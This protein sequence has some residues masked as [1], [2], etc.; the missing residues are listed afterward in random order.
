MSYSLSLYLVDP[1]KVRGVVGSG[2]DKLRRMMGGAFKT[3]FP[4]D[5]DY[6]SHE[7][8]RGAPTRYDA[9]RAV[10]A[11][12]PFVEEF[13]WQYGY[14]Y[15][16]VCRFHGRS[17]FNNCFSPFR[18][19]WLEEVDKGLVALGIRAVE[20]SGFSYSSLPGEL[21]RPDFVPGYG[22]WSAQECSSALKQ[23]EASTPEQRAALDSEVLEAIESVVGWLV[24]AREKEGAGV[25]GFFY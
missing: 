14:A 3:Q 24:K 23:W 7:I 13:A 11:G 8:E 1:A 18:S 2:D 12:G 9:L 10:I 6:F 25:V 5:D 20:I 16:M 15:E 17:L 19:G 21:P 22:E 4:H